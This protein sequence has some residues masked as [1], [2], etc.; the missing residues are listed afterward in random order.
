VCD[1][2][3]QQA[4]TGKADAAG[5]FPTPVSATRSSRPSHGWAPTSC[6]SARRTSRRSPIYRCTT[7]IPS[8]G[9]SSPRR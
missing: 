3:R 4:R 8:I 2:A 1:R 6:R 9:S 5:A 7:A